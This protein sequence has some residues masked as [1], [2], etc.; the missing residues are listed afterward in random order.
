[1]NIATLAM[2]L[3]GF[4]SGLSYAK[5]EQ[6]EEKILRVKSAVLG[7]EVIVLAIMVKELF[8]AICRS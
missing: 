7:A 5:K 1:M 6:N 8:A 3:V 2:L 4:S